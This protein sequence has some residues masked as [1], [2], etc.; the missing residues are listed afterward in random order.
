MYSNTKIILVDDHLMFRE[1]IKLLIETEGMG[2]V[3]AEV[4]NGQ[5]LLCLLENQNPDL[6]LMD[7][8]MPVMGGLEATIKAMI[9]KPKLKILVLTML[10]NKDTYTN[11]INAGVMGFVLKTSGKQELE[12]AIKTVIGGEG[13]FSSELLHSI[14]VNFG[15]QKSGITNSTLIDTEFTNRELE[16]LEYL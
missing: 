12:K 6:V 8:E 3:I 14:I 5:E 11:M 10:G 15:K 1:G 9:I 13:Y 16:I 7:I 4:D 2:H